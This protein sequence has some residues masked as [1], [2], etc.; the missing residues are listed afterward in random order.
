LAKATTAKL[1][2]RI[3][4]SEEKIRNLNRTYQTE[5]EELKKKEQGY[6]KMKENALSS[7]WKS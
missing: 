5:V 4:E 1:E 7:V 6:K 2:T 3:K